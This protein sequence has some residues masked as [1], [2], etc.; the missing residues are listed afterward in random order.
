[1]PGFEAVQRRSVGQLTGIQ[2]G[3]EAHIKIGVEIQ[4]ALVV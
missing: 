2:L 3:R 4:A 1:V